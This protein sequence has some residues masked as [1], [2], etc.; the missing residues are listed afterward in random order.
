MVDKGL[1]DR[2]GGQ[3]REGG[4]EERKRWT[5][6]ARPDTGSLEPAGEFKDNKT[7]KAAGGKTEL[8]KTAQGEEGT[9]DGGGEGSEDS[10]GM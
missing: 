7:G 6:V 5:F 3:V 1:P 9:D 10:R 8:G 2:G 4:R